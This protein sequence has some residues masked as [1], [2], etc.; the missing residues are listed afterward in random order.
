MTC[1]NAEARGCG[2]G[3]TDGALSS[4]YAVER[5]PLYALC[6]CVVA[7]GARGGSQGGREKRANDRSVLVC[8]RAVHSLG[9]RPTLASPGLSL[10][11]Q[12]EG[13]AQEAGST[14]MRTAVLVSRRILGFI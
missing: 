3:V 11:P 6:L 13:K 7:D 10:A 12:G 1:S 14:Q 9:L 2:A 5:A 8:F 4:E